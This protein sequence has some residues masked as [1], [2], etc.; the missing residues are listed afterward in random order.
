[1]KAKT[2]L[3]ALMVIVPSLAWAQHEDQMPAAPA[4]TEYHKALLKDVGTWDAEMKLW[5]AP[6][7]DPMISKGEE[8]NVML[9]DGLWVISEFKGEVAGMKFV[10]HGQFGYDTVKEKYVGTWIDSMNTSM[11]TMEGTVDKST[12][13][14]TMISH[15]TDPNTGQPTESKIISYYP[16]NNTK[17]MEMH[18]P[19]PASNGEFIKHMEIKYTRKQS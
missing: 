7:M 2:I 5:M 10:G 6:G 3:A 13:K 16:D 1:M 4:P 17:I 18:M 8:T 11:S 12:G 19:T 14:L 9:G 15:G